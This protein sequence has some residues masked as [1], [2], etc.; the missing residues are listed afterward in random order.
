VQIFCTKV[1]CRAF[2]CLYLIR[3]K[4]PKRLLYKKGAYKMLTKMTPGEFDQTFE[5]CNETTIQIRR[6]E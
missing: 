6:E 3:E 1:L 4:L 2:I 5:L